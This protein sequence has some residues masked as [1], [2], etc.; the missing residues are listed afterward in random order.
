MYFYSDLYENEKKLWRLSRKLNKERS[1]IK[2]RLV[3][4]EDPKNE[5][6]TEVYGINMVPIIIFLTPKGEVAARRSLPLSSSDVINEITDR[7]NNGE[8]PNPATEQLR[9]RILEA[10][11]AVTSRNDLTQLIIDQ[12]V[13]DILEANSESEVY[14][15]VNSHISAINHIMRDLQEFKQSLQRFSKEQKEFIV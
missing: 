5:D 11:K 7:I 14:E 3:N 10:F 6:L 1:D 12:V 2:I 9:A 8:L 15:L 13:N 4:V